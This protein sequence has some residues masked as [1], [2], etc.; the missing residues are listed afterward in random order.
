MVFGPCA[1]AYKYKKKNNKKCNH[2]KSELKTSKR[3]AY[4]HITYA[5]I[6]L[7]LKIDLLLS[8]YLHRCFQLSGRFACGGLLCASRRC[9]RF[10]RTIHFWLT[11]CR[12]FHEL[13]VIGNQL[14]DH[15]NFFWQRFAFEVCNGNKE[16]LLR[17]I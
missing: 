10:A 9:F 5:V 4:V 1:I 12:I 13:L 6:G 8:F 14:L 15:W 16:I 7:K 3:F 17:L 2:K 11:T